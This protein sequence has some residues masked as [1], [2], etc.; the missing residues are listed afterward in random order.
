MKMGVSLYYE[1]E[2]AASERA[3]EE[4]VKE[5]A[6]LEH[7]RAWM[8]EPIY[9]FDPV[10]AGHLKGNSKFAPSNWPMEDWSFASWWD[11][12]FILD[13]LARWS[14]EHNLRWKLSC[15]GEEVGR[16]REGEMDKA[17]R[18]FLRQLAEM[19]GASSD[20][21]ANEQRAAEI[22][23]RYESSLQ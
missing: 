21:S 8:S 13:A 3:V 11:F 15:E 5:A 18:E 6:R 16:I 10:K 2:E 1:T 20:E 4:I 23:R 17:A 12:R 7:S 14:H 19:G 9:F 22:I